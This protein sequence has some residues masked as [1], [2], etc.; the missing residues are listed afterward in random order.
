MMKRE[1]LAER[2]RK[3]PDVELLVNLMN[4]ASYLPEA[5]AAARLELASRNLTAQ[6]VEEAKNL[7]LAMRPTTL[8]AM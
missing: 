2:Y 5:L 6:Q 8:P 7:A 4:P 1:E 3:L